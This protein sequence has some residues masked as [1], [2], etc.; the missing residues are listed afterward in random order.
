MIVS[1]GKTDIG[2][3]RKSN[4]DFFLTSTEQ[5]YLFV[6]CDGMGG[7]S[8]GDVASRTTAESIK[9]YVHLQST[10]DLDENKAE[11]LLK[12]AV[13]YANNV[14]H[15]RAKTSETFK[16]MGTTCDVCL[17]DF[18]K[19]YIVHVGDSRVYRL[20]QGVFSQLTKDH[21]LVDEMVEKGV[22]TKEEAKT[23][24]DKNIITRAVG[25]NP[26]V[27]IDFISDDLLPDDILLMCSDGL[28]N[29]VSDFDIKRL[30]ISADKPEEIVNHLVGLAN[31]NGGK[32]NIT[33]VYIKVLAKEEA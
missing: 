6:L 10:M 11:K 25:T 28:S 22:I 18:D 8:S 23:H 33:A 14:V 9:T 3:T 26:T 24:P 16:G 19:L 13:S 20:R 29:M 15:T 27:D 32:D 21:S 7:H 2:K 17:L 1:F 30:L 12:N 31:Q 4:Q 5:P